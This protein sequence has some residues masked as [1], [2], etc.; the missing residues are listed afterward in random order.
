MLLEDNLNLNC[1]LPLEFYYTN[2]IKKASHLNIHLLPK[3]ISIIGM[4]APLQ[5]PRCSPSAFA[6][7]PMITANYPYL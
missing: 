7:I 6:N 1:Q 3:D 4:A 5:Q 2:S